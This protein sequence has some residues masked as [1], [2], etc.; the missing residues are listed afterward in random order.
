MYTYTN[1]NKIQMFYIQFFNLSKKNKCS[2]IK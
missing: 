1:F 2:E